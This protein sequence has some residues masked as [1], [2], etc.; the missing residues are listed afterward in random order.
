MNTEAQLK[1]QLELLSTYLQQIRI[2]SNLTQK[3][4]AVGTGLNRNTIIRIENSKNFS[5]HTLLILAD[6]YELSPADLLSILN[7]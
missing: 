4:A 2:S 3:E 7:D 5:I 6:F 1:L